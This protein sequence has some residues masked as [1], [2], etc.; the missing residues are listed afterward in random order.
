[1]EQRT[2]PLNSFLQEINIE[3]DNSIL[4]KNPI[5]VIPNH[6]L[7]SDDV[8]IIK[9]LRNNKQKVHIHNYENRKYIEM[10]GGEFELALMIIDKF[11][12]PLIVS[13]TTMWIG[14]RIK[15]WKDQKNESAPDSLVDPPDF[16]MEYYIKDDKKY[17]K[18]EGDA[19]TALRELKKLQDD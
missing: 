8:T 11:A 18:I 5:I 10:R 17:V 13:I 19:D 16:K 6:M 9:R 2:I 1:M 15:S 3:L 7:N 12:I 4:E 14:N